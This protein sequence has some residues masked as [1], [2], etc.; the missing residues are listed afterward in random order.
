LLFINTIH[1][2]FLD[3][4]CYLGFNPKSKTILLIHH[5]NA[6]LNPYLIFDIKH[7]IKTI[8]T[9][10]ASILISK[11]IFPKFDAIN[12]IYHPLK[13]Y[14]KKKTD[15]KKKIF[16]LPSSIFENIND[17]RINENN[18]KLNIAIPGLIQ[19]HR[20]DYNAVIPAFENL[21]KDNKEKIKLCVLG[22]PIGSFGK[23][24]KNKFNDM[25]KNEYDIEIF[26]HFI[27]E[28]IFKDKLL[29]SDIILAP[30]R[31]NTRADGDIKEIY[32][33][34]VGSGI[35]FNAIKYAKPIIVPSEFNMLP[36]LSSS[37]LKYS[38]SK[39][40]QYIIEHLISNP[41]KLQK[42][43]SNAIINSQIFSLQ[44]LQNYFEKKILTWIGK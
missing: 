13:E 31:I 11:F 38:N 34:T 22:F 35:I 9:N 40:L 33:R 36:E 16:T 10:A 32:G 6:W 29:Q 27:P 12:V 23:Y 28:D 3:L 1:E 21:F 43:K 8:D 25:K 17:N 41:D 2:T 4:F 37:T 26:E 14:I 15:Y 20:K 39:E 44:K 5:V 42:I 19:E 30:I 7:P 24:I 18:D